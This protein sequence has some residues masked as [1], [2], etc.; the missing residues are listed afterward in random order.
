MKKYKIRYLEM[1]ETDVQETVKYIAKTLQNH[2][3]AQSLLEEIYKEIHKRSE[4]PFL[5]ESVRLLYDPHNLYYR[6]YV[7]NYV[8]YYVVIDDIIEIRRFLYGKRNIESI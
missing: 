5:S 6:I 8:I 4:M 7:K 1:F 3:A 2:A